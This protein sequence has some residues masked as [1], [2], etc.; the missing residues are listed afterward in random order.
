MLFSI[1]KKNNAV[2]HP[3]AVMLCPEL[4][5]LSQEE[6]LY[7][8]LAFDYTSPYKQLPELERIRRAKYQVWQKSDY[9]I[10]N[11]NIQKAIDAYKGLQY[12]HDRELV[13]KYK[14]TIE[15]FGQMLVE[16]SN[17]KKLKELDEGIERL[18]TR[19][20]AL[21]KKVDSNDEAEVLRGGGELTWIE[22]WQRNLRAFQKSKE[23]EGI[24]N[25]E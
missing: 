13:I 2:L 12:D 3:Q 14:A 22:K 17:P 23:K 25:L 10:Q 8:I 9:V 24:V 5:D 1:D 18:T 7:V 20:T 4:K 15:K 6:L 11:D 19:V 21:Q 16:E